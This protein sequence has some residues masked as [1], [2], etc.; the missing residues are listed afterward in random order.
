MRMLWWRIWW[1]IRWRLWSIW[2][3]IFGHKWRVTKVQDWYYG[4]VEYV[5]E[6]CKRCL[7]DPPE[8]ID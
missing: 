3:A 1:P 6:G 7:C 8:F 4:E 5:N 2:C